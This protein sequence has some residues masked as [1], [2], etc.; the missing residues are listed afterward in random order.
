MHAWELA[1]S[2]REGSWPSCR[3]ALRADV[4]DTQGGTTREGIHLA[5]MAGTVDLLQ[6][7]H[8]GLELRED[9]LWLNPRLPAEIE[10][11]RFSVHYRGH[12]IELDVD[13]LRVRVSLAAGRAAPVQLD[14]RGTRCW[15]HAEQTVELPL[16]AAATAASRLDAV[17]TTTV[18][19]SRPAA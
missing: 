14:V 9:I 13:H 18:G 10:R 8:T 5:A 16:D 19:P 17:P 7:G 3:R 12:P 4:D 1:R 6:R 15:A 2:D 11:L